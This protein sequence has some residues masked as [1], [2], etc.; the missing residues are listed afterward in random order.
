MSLATGTNYRIPFK[1]KRHN[2]QRQ[3]RPITIVIMLKQK[4]HHFCNRSSR[5][6]GPKSGR[7][8]KGYIQLWTI[9]KSI[10]PEYD[11]SNTGI[12]TDPEE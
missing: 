3:K 12:R 1:S 9:H 5:S 2:I 8:Y 10:P 11:K 6:D 7:K 4:L